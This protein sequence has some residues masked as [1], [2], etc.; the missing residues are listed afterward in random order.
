[1]LKLKSKKYELG[2]YKKGM[3]YV[4][5]IVVLSIFAVMSSVVMFNYGSFESK[6]DIKNV[7]SDVGLKIVQAQKFSVNGK[8]PPLAQQTAIGEQI[9][10]GINA[11]KPSYGVYFNTTTDNKSFV[12][13]TDVNQNGEYDV[14][15]S[16]NVEFLETIS[17]NKGN[18]ISNVEFLLPT[19][20]SCLTTNALTIFFKRPDSGATFIPPASSNCYAR[21]TVKTPS[22]ADISSSID[23][24][25][26]GRIQIN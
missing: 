12:Y 14:G 25:P 11:W 1:M 18:Y 24:Y 3:T 19:G 7:A 8:L 20:G 16:P 21:I 4:E 22:S 5:L 13:F 9:A 15:S 17:I 6:I 2:F 23:V 26:S 10:G